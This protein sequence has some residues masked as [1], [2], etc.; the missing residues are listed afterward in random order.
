MEY[1]I[2]SNI[3]LLRLI[4][5]VLP[6]KHKLRFLIDRYL[7]VGTKL[8][9]PYFGSW[10]IC[11]TVNKINQST[12]ESVILE[13]PA[14]QPERALIK[15]LRSELPDNMTFIDIGGNIGTFLSQFID[16][17]DRAVVFEPIP[18]LN[19]VIEQS[20]EFN[21][22]SKVTLVK[23]ALGDAPG[24]VKMLDNNNSSVVS[25]NINEDVIEVSTVDSEIMHLSKVDFM[26]IDVEGYELKVLKGSDAAIRKYRPVML[27]ELH[28]DF[29]KHYGEDYLDVIRFLEERNY[30]IRYYS[31]LQELTS[32]KWER[33][34]L[35]W[36]GNP[37]Q[38]F[39]NLADFQND[40]S[41]KNA[42][43]VY[44]IVAHF[45]DK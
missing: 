43:P 22:D 31:F 8:A 9:V 30:S 41:S 21:N 27:I 44:H 23:K 6:L 28:V 13:G 12:L 5:R 16:K 36:K 26:K 25:G 38:E 14:S 2:V 3:G 7:Q 24:K 10:H 17:C 34:M 1:K 20:M 40:L 35:R 39:R 37:G 33:L 45:K 18:N 32:T 15:K 4:S 19:K 29:L 11:T 42:K